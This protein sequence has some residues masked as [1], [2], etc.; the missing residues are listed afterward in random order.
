MRGGEGIEI[1]QVDG[2]QEDGHGSR[3]ENANH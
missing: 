1:S 2:F 3:H